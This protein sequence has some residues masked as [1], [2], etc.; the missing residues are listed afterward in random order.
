MPTNNERPGERRVILRRSRGQM[1]FSNPG[2]VD[3]APREAPVIDDDIDDAIDP[4]QMDD[5]V[6]QQTRRPAAGPRRDDTPERNPA[7]MLM[8]VDESGSAA[9]SREYR[10]AL[11]HKMLLRKMPLHEIARH[12]NVSIS[13]IE[14][15]RVRLKAA[16]REAAKEMNIDE[17]IGSQVGL[18]DEI[19]AMSLRIASKTSGAGA[20]P[21]A[22]QLAAMRTTLAANAD[23]TRF[24]GATGVLDILRFRKGDTGE[25]QSDIQIVM[26]RTARMLAALGDDG[27]GGMG[28]F[29]E[30]SVNDVEPESEDL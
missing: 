16:L 4:D 30:F 11:L 6:R 9:Y 3:G 8:D 24:L 20:V 7:Q 21:T 29:G 17:M 13:T 18:Y 2:R 27:S 28:D 1:P 25:A 10:L 12:L 19:T 15:D 22:M 26:E 5:H 23:K 14:K